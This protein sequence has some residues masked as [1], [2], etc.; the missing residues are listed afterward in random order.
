[1]R[2]RTRR[3]PLSGMALKMSRV[4]FHMR[5]VTWQVRS[6]TKLLRSELEVVLVVLDATAHAEEAALGHGI[7]DVARGVPHARRHLAGAIG[8]EALA[9]GTGGCSG[10]SRCD[11]ARGGSRSRAWH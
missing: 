9:I 7:E 6:E 2:P 10:S 11:R 4:A 1:M 8:D 5:A 3:K